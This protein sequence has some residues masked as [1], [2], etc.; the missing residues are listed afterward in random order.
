MTINGELMHGWAKEL[1]P[2][3]RSI[4]GPGVRETLN[5]IKRIIPDLDI[6]EINTGAKVFDWEIPNEWDIRDAYILDESGN[7]IVDFKNNNLHVVNYSKPVDRSITLDELSDHLYSLPDQPEAIPY[8]TSYYQERWGFCV[9]ENLRKTLKEGLYHVYIDSR[10][11]PGVLN[12]AD[13]I[14]PGQSHEEIFFSTYICHPSMANNELSGPVVATA[15][16]KWLL[17]FKNKPRYTYRFVFVPETIG[18]ITYLSKNLDHLKENV[19]AGFNLTCLGDDRC[20][21]FVPSR[22]GDTLAD[23]VARHVLANM[24][25]DYIKYTWLDRGSDERQYCAPGIDLPVVNMMRSKHGTYPE[26]HTSLDDLKLVTP[27]GL[28]GS[29]QIHK[30]AIKIFENDMTVKSAV[31]GEPQLGKRGLRPQVGEKTNAEKV[32]TLMNIL[33]YCDG[34]MTLLEIAD[35]TNESFDTVYSTAQE[36]IKHGILLNDKIK[37]KE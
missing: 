33:S 25:N 1:F 21:S 6:H 34:K 2:I 28:E 31:L 9:S 36:L 8:I 3:C 10:I 5:Y 20:F 11:K 18:S 32:M 29:F 35:I 26:Y 16:I 12:Y 13:I 17:S 27:E 23:R 24:D 19:I 7:K 14:I 4:T 22:H 37:Q 30:N 15:L